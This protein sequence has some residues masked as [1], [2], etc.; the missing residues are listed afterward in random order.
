MAA[1]PGSIERNAERLRELEAAATPAQVSAYRQRH[2]LSWIY[3]DNALD[4][5]V[6]EPTELEA[7]LANRP[8]TDST[9]IPVHD[10]IRQYAA[11]IALVRELAQKKKID[12]TA[13]TLKR[14]YLTLDPEEADAKGPLKYRKS[15]PLHRVY[16]H[17]ISEPDKI[18]PQMREFFQWVGSAETK[19]LVHP[20][21]VASKTHFTLL[22]IY[23]FTKHS[24]KI[25]R[26]V[27]N[28]MLLHA[29]F[30]VAILHATDRQRYYDALRTSPD[31][32]STLVTDALV[33]SLESAVRY[34]EREQGLSGTP[35]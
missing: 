12:I 30:P 34:F 32:L 27:M 23:P 6:Y 26:L 11:A 13:D 16:F 29:G 4:G 28:L 25:A 14:I 20:T 8:V 18:A 7:A 31:A 10:E 9:L 3:H 33:N 22:Q 24:G 2:D 21:R 19:R 17:D 35:L 1:R 5:V 15:M